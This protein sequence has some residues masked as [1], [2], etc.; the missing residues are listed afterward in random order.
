VS[1]D[2]LEVEEVGPAGFDAVEG[3][4]A[5]FD[6]WPP[7][8]EIL[9]GALLAAAVL[10]ILSGVA[11]A[12]ANTTSNVS[13]GVVLRQRGQL[14]ARSAGPFP[15]LLVIGSILL[16]DLEHIV[17]ARP[18]ARSDLSRW[19]L[20]GAGAVAVVITICGVAGAL[21]VLIAPRDVFAVRSIGFRLGDAVSSVAGALLGAAAAWIVA[22]A[23]ADDVGVDG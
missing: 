13:T 16:A 10:L 21:N 3:E 8:A 14:V 1:D 11:Y 20:R 12:F 9:G 4:P 5:L 15:G 18:P 19:V 17:S 22:S 23:S 7:R 6:P 2:E